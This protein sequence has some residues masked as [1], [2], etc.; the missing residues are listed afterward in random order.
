MKRAVILIVSLVALGAAAWIASAG[1]GYRFGVWDLSAAFSILRAKWLVYTALGAGG[2]ALIGALVAL[3]TGPRVL[4]PV[5]LAAALAA[6]AAGYAPKAMFDK[7]KANPFIHDVTTDFDNP[8]QIVRYAGAERKNP[9]DYRGGETVKDTGKTV[10][11]LQREAF[12]DIQP[13][14]FQGDIETVGRAVRETLSGMGLAE[15]LSTELPNGSM[16]FETYATSRWFGFKDDFVV[17]LT[18]ADGS[19]RVDVRSESRVGGS[20][21]GANAARVRLFSEKLKAKL[22]A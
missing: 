1:L 4:F 3:F 8:P 6:G 11:E 16:R 9:P 10:A 22:N 2:L 5:A 17:R 13:M 7:V 20:D 21:L 15:P 12:P 14:T 19:V 18:P